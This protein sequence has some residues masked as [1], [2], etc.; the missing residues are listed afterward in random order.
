M[1]ILDRFFKKD[2]IIE[3][4]DIFISYSYKDQEI[5]ERICNVLELN[6]FKWAG[7]SRNSQNISDSVVNAINHSQLILFILSNSSNESQNV[8][9][10]LMFAFSNSKPII[11]FR[12]DDV[13]PCTEIEF[14][15]RSSMWIDAY[16]GYENKM[17]MLVED[18]SKLIKNNKILR[19]DFF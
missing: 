7:S 8:K 12:I 18:I 10:E 4:P 14:L 6:D 3:N 1:N 17:E 2:K 15:M 16:D 19:D 11:G 9:N 5:V 13:I